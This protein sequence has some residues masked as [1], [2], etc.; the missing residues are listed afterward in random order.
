MA[1]RI[2]LSSIQPPTNPDPSNPAPTIAFLTSVQ[3]AIVMIRNNLLSSPPGSDGMAQCKACSQ[4]L[5]SLLKPTFS[6]KLALLVQTAIEGG[7]PDLI[8]TIVLIGN[9]TNQ[10]MNL[11][12]AEWKSYP[13]MACY[14]L[15]YADPALLRATTFELCNFYEQVDPANSVVN[16]PLSSISS[17]VTCTVDPACQWLSS[18]DA[19]SKTCPSI[20]NEYINIDLNQKDGVDTFVKGIC[21]GI[22][23][24]GSGSSTSPCETAM[25][26]ALQNGPN[27]LISSMQKCCKQRQSVAQAKWLRWM[28]IGVAVVLCIVLTWVVFELFRKMTAEKHMVE[29]SPTQ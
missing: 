21:G 6:T 18:F 20:V 13:A 19:H 7:R 3:E 26:N 28:I 14:L 15:L 5:Q 24:G 17:F 22:F 4:A 23:L 2:D 8:N 27:G 1:C 9:M 29:T 12:D 11:A 10:P 25:K 16:I